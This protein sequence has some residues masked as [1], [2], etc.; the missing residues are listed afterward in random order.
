[1]MGRENFKLLLRRILI[2]IAV[3]FFLFLLFL[4]F[5]HLYFFKYPETVTLKAY[6]IVKP[7]QSLISIFKSHDFMDAL[8]D[9]KMR[10]FN[11]SKKN[12]SEPCLIMQFDRKSS[13]ARLVNKLAQLKDPLWEGEKNQLYK[14]LE[15]QVGVLKECSLFCPVFMP[16]FVLGG[17][18]C[19]EYDQNLNIVN[20]TEP[21]FSD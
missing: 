15:E 8:T 11:F 7:G 2:A 14:G 13:K 4:L 1:M 6:N 10:F 3:I 5:S 20:V 9:N 18:F 16:A 17:S 21:R 19:I 12:Q